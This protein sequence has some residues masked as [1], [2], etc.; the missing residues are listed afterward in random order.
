MHNEI[1]TLESLGRKNEADFRQGMVSAQK[2]MGVLAQWGKRYSDK[3]PET[4]L[5]FGLGELLSRNGEDTRVPHIFFPRRIWKKYRQKPDTI[6][7]LLI[8]VGENYPSQ[9]KYVAVRNMMGFGNKGIVAYPLYAPG[10][11]EGRIVVPSYLDIQSA[12]V[13]E[14]SMV[15]MHCY[16]TPVDI[17]FSQARQLLSDWLT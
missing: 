11:D 17:T 3:F 12:L 4:Y 10:I 15:R 2:A 8:K 9:Q 7:E 1:E 14:E 6:K 16:G 13:F 5:Y